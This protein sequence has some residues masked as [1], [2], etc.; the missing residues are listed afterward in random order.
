MCLTC[1]ATLM[2]NEYTWM[3]TTSGNTVTVTK[4]QDQCKLGKFSDASNICNGDCLANCAKCND[5]TTCSMCKHGFFLDESDSTNIKCV[6]FD[7]CPP[8]TFADK[9]TNNC[10]QCSSPCATCEKNLNRCLTCE[11]GKKFFADI[12]KCF[13]SCPEGTY[14]NGDLCLKCTDNV[15][16]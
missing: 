16:N 6:S 1:D 3:N 12:N 4:C 7:M 9:S 5:A 8:G 13:T 11:V 10:E 14:T 15:I 2:A